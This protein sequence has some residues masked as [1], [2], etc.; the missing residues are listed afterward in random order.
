[1]K[2]L[3]AKDVMVPLQDYPHALP[4]N[5]LREAARML[6]VAQIRVGQRTRSMPRVVLVFDEDRHLLGVVRRRDILK[7]LADLH[8]ELESAPDVQIKSEADADL[9]EVFSPDDREHWNKRLE[10]PIGDVLRE[11]SGRVEADDSILKVISEL[12]GQDNHMVEVVEE[13]QVIG[14]VR[15]VEVLRRVYQELS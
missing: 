1:M 15:T 5:T 13:D 8:P 14:V 3:T 12:V 7:G 6:V 11:I 10:K 2:N 4:T 9:A